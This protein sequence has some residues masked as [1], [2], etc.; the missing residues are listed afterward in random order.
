MR[1]VHVDVACSAEMSATHVSAAA[2]RSC[3]SNGA[4]AAEK[5]ECRGARVAAS[6]GSASDRAMASARCRSSSPRPSRVLDRAAAT[7]DASQTD[8]G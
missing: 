1:R 8:S 2:I 4:P 3:T 6:G 7:L 5:K